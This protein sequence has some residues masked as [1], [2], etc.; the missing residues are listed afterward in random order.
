MT[1]HIIYLVGD[2][3][4]MKFIVGPGWNEAFETAKQLCPEK[5]TLMGIEN[6]A[7]CTKVHWTKKGNIKTT[8]YS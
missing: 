4:E 5:G 1:F 8:F 3:L 7:H 6:G 2:E